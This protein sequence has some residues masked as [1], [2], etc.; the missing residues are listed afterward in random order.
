MSKRERAKKSK[1]TKKW[2][3]RQNFAT[4]FT[5]FNLSLVQTFGRYRAI[6]TGR[7]KET[8]HF[9]ETGVTYT[10]DNRAA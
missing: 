2:P 6:L 7:E 9:P 5:Y 3:I 8:D 1:K 4:N 10:L